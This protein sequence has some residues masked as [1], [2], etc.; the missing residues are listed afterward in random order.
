MVIIGDSDF[1]KDD[2]YFEQTVNRDIFVNAV[3]WLIMDGDDP[4]LSIRPKRVIQRTLAISDQVNMLLSVF[5]IVL[6]PL[7]AFATAAALWWQRR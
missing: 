6:L 4:T 2:P 3:S 7:T 1:A 5:G